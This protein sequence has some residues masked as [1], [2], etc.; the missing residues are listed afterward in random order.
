MVNCTANI[1]LQ[2]SKFFGYLNTEI[3][4]VGQKGSDNL[5]RTIQAMCCHN[6]LLNLQRNRYFNY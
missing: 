3:F 2:L 1:E 5:V 4:G 6:S